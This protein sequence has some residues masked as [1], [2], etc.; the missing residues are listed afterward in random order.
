M[1]VS[2]GLGQRSL[3]KQVLVLALSVSAVVSL[4]T[5]VVVAWQ[6]LK[7][8]KEAVEREMMDALGSVNSSLVS[9][10]ESSRGRV[11]RQLLVFQRMLGELPSPDG[12]LTET[13]VAGEVMTVRAGENVLNGNSA[14]LQRMRS[15]TGAEP[16]LVVRHNNRWIR[17]ATLLRG[18]DGSPLTGQP[19]PADD[20]VATT[21]DSQQAA[22]N[23]VYRN[24]R[25]YALHV[26]PLKDDNG[27]IFGGIALQVDMSDDVAS[28]LD[29]IERTEVAGHGTMFAM[30]PSVNGTSEFLVH[31]LY[32]GKTV[33]ET[34]EADRPFFR[35]LVDHGLG[36][37]EAHLSTD[38]S[39]MLVSYQTVPNWG[40]TL[41]ATG[42]KA[43][44]MAMQYKQLA[45]I[46][47]LLV[48]GGLLTGL[49]IYYQMS[50]AL[51]PVRDVVEGIARLGD[52]DLTRDVPAGPRGSRNEIHIMADRINATRARIAHLAQQMNSTGSQVATATTQTLQALHQIGKGTEVQSEAASGVA[53]AVEQ[54]TVSISQIADNTREAN[55][56]SR[57]SSTAAEEGAV[58]VTQTV[59][60]IEK[61]A[62]QVASSAEVVQELEASSRQISAV[63][64]TIQEIAEQTNLLALNA[65]IEAARAGEEGRGFSVVA[66]EV[67]GLAERTKTSTSQ[68]AQVIAA[69]QKQTSVAADAMRQVN[70]DM[71]R[72]AEGARQAGDVLV[73]IREAAGRTAEVIAD[74][75]NAAMEQKSASEQIASRVEQIAQYSEESAAAVQQS[76]ASAESLQNQAQVLD[77]TIRT[78][79]T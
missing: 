71:Q 68:I 38:D 49:L 21:M 62:S 75:S 29:F 72:S 46:V 6:G 56:F 10:F 15:Y 3:A 19:V 30:T 69:V 40:W 22:T 43:E 26:R 18:S 44:F 78:L 27:K 11:E 59:S 58:V 51:R 73:R 8:G 48:A 20:F 31:P 17:A 5:A 14:I 53:A 77:E 35:D 39:D 36:S 2:L 63:V 65:A 13:G 70:A 74:I 12:T 67:R 28:A 33:E 7:A 79:R 32:K 16:E 50:M 45:L 37:L 52:G 41:V 60:E 54:L 24:K 64:K 25:W 55:N 9:S 66:D 61:M 1:A 4:V 42:P 23:V 47:G 76:V 34:P 57:T